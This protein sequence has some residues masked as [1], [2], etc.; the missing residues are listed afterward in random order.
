RQPGNAPRNLR[1]QG[2][3]PMDS[4]LDATRQSAG[5]AQ[6]PG[7]GAGTNAP[8]I[9]RLPMSLLARS[10]LAHHWRDIREAALGED[11][12]EG[13]LPI[14][15]LGMDRQVADWKPALQRR[16]VARNRRRIAIRCV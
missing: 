11:L 8:G 1:A 4:L 2:T 5:A 9:G 15:G 12:G 3:H 16:R 6:T 10:E 14:H 7:P 13:G